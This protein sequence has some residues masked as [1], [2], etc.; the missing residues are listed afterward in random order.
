MQSVTSDDLI[1][2][3]RLAAFPHF[4]VERTVGPDAEWVVTVTEAD[5]CRR[6]ST[7]SRVSLASAVRSLMTVRANVPADP[8]YPRQAGGDDGCLCR[9]CGQEPAE[10]LDQ[11]ASCRHGTTVAD[12]REFLRPGGEWDRR[13]AMRP[14]PY[15]FSAK[16]GR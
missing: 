2:F 1:Q 7:T 12:D 16:Q 13:R 14:S 11:C 10:Y 15:R 4:R 3:Q 8:V 6:L 9:T 5:P